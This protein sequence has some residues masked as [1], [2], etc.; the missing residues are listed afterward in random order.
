MWFSLRIDPG[1]LLFARAPVRENGAALAVRARTA[2]SRELRIADWRLRILGM[3]RA[4]SAIV[5][6]RH[7]FDFIDRLVDQY[8][9]DH[10]KCWKQQTRLKPC[11]TTRATA[12]HP[13]N[14]FVD[15]RRSKDRFCRQSDLQRALDRDVILERVGSRNE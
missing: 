14:K 7:R 2:P 4:I 3:N 6:A 5:G 15:V 10:R 8:P 1:G 11:A 9:T 13:L 12:R